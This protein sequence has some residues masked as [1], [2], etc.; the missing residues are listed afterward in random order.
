ML[1]FFPNKNVIEHG[2]STAEDRMGRP[3]VDEELCI[4]CGYCPEVCHA[5]FELV[6][7]KWNV[8]RPEGCS[9]CDCQEAIDTRPVQAESW[10]E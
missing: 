5:V 1:L 10:G 8:V 6:D 2:R 9:A 3:V 7:E 4:G